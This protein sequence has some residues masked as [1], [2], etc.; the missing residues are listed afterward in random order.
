LRLAGLDRGSLKILAIGCGKGAILSFLRLCGHVVHGIDVDPDAIRECVAAHPQIEIPV[1]SGDELPFDDACFD[2]VLN[3][4]VVEHIRASN[5]HLRKV[6]R[7]LKPNGTYLLQTPN[8][9]TNI[10]FEMLRQWRK[11]HTGPLQSYRSLLQDHCALRSYR[12]L[13]ERFSRIGYQL[14]FMDMPVVNDYFIA[15]RR[16]YPGPVGQPCW[17]S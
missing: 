4:D 7:V 13:A 1:A 12:Q 3:L 9:W 15:N 2:V 5:R 14:T 6:T 16:T 8:K 10:P 11:F 17:R